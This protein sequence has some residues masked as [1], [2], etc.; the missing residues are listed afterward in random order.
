MPGRPRMPLNAAVSGFRAKLMPKF[1]K[2]LFAR[3]MARQPRAQLKRS[4]SSHFKGLMNRRQRT[5]KRNKPISA[6]M[7]IAGFVSM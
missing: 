1:D 7:I 3:S 2:S 4:F 5:Y 6:A